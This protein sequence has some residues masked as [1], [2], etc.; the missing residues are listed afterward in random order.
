M[1]TIVLEKEKENELITKE[2]DF[3]VDLK[4]SLI[5]PSKLSVSISAFANASG[6]DIFLG[7]KEDTRTR[8]REIDGRTSKEQ[9]NDIVTTLESLE[10]LNGEYSLTYLVF[11]NNCIGLQITIFKNHHI[12]KSTDGKIYIRKNAEN[13]QVDTEEK[14]RRLELDKGIYLY[15]NTNVPE[16]DIADAI[17]SKVYGDFANKIIPNIDKFN[18]LRAQKLCVGSSLNIA[19]VLLF[20]DEPQ[21][22]LP[23]KS[24]IKIYRY[25]TSGE[26]N[27][28]NLDGAPLTIEGCAYNQI[29]NA[30]KKVKEIIESIKKL[31]AK[32][33]DIC[34]PDSTLHE[35]ITN[36]VLHRDYSITT[37][38]QI[39]IYDNRVEI[40]SPGKLAGHITVDNILHEQF[41]R[42]PKL[43]RLMN[44]FPSPPNKDV[45]EGLNTAF[46]AMEQLR[47]KQPEIEEKENSV[48]V[49]IRHEKLASPEESVMEY[50]QTH[51]EITNA[52]GRKIT[53]ITSENVMKR[54]FLKLR[55]A[56]YIV[57]ISGRGYG[58]RAAWTSKGVNIDPASNNIQLSIFDE[59]KKGDNA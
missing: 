3:F 46:M 22:T 47:L 5:K 56:G 7:I 50:L 1:D 24:S 9:Y 17:N 54:V 52:I 12:V 20:T 8:K 42:N 43:V 48:L 25:K 27:R 16:S 30:V 45:G 19:G 18:W 44:K 2:E 28:S 21:T 53:G 13:L 40:E 6:G 10:G 57:K 38:I 41:A 59:G 51:N 14:R 58:T 26:G 29:Y 31:D 37:D 36:A 34:Y 33:E 35:I 55:D 23:K 49:I 11:R 4:S 32:F 15:E 39:R